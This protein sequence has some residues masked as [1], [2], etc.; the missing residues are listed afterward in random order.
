V[1]YVLGGKVLCIMLS[2]LIFLPEAKEL[3][4]ESSEPDG[5]Y[6]NS[7]C[8]SVKVPEIPAT[9]TKGHCHFY[10]LPTRTCS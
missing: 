6:V 3:E 10:W 2:L 9:N 5:G 8:Q 7:I 1:I 4:I